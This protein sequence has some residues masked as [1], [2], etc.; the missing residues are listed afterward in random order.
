MMQ[1]KVMVSDALNSINSSLKTY[2]DM[3]SQTENKELRGALQS[4]R[5]EE[6]NSQYELYMIAKNKNYYTPP[7]MANQNEINSLKSVFT[8]TTGWSGN[9]GHVMGNSGGT[10]MTGRTSL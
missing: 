6:E 4:M 9:T 3:I 2:A 1:E 7:A 5:N 10:D 8:G